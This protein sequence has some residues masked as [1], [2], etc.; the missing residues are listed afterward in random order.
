[1]TR[2]VIIWL[3]VVSGCVLPVKAEPIRWVSFDVP[4]ESLEYAMQADI[5]SYEQESHISWIDILAV[6]ACRTGGKCS[7]SSV[8]KAVKELKNG[9][10]PEECLGSLY[11]YYDY[12]H[13]AYQAELGG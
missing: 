11:R 6:A 7:L 2:R 8:Q 10:S 9:A 13:H 12:Y 1:M 4:Y 3:I 5:V